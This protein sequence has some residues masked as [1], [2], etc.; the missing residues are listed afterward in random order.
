[1]PST[2]DNP[3]QVDGHEHSLTTM[4]FEA[5]HL[6]RNDEGAIVSFFGEA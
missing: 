5:V 2:L 6:P 1:V 4:S 3:L